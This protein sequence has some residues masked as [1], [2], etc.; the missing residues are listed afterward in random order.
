MRKLFAILLSGAMILSLAGCKKNEPSNPPGENGTPTVSV[1]TETPTQAVSEPKPTKAPETN[2]ERPTPTPMIVIPENTSTNGIKLTGTVNRPADGIGTP[3]KDFIIPETGAVSGWN[4]SEPAPFFNPYGAKD[5]YSYTDTDGLSKT[6]RYDSLTVSYYATD[7]I[8]TVTEEFYGQKAVLEISD[9]QCSIPWLLYT[10]KQAGATVYPTDYN[11]GA[12][13]LK[14]N[15][16]TGWWG[17]IRSGYDTYRVELLRIHLIEPGKEQKIDEKDPYFDD[18]GIQYIYFTETPGKLYSFEATIEKEWKGENNGYSV[19]AVKRSSIGVMETSLNKN[20][21]MSDLSKIT[22]CLGMHFVFDNVPIVSGMLGICIQRKCDNKEAMPIAYSIKETGTVSTVIYGDEP[23]VVRFIGISEGSGMKLLPSFGMSVYHSDMYVDDMLRQSF[24]DENGNYCFTVP[25][26]YYDAQFGIEILE[27]QSSYINLIPVSAG[28]ITEVTIPE[29]YRASFAAIASGYGEIS[30]E[31]GNME[32]I[33]AA[34]K[35]GKGVLTVTVHDPLERD[36]FPDPS[37]FKISENGTEGKITKVDRQAADTNIV[38]C[39]DSSGS[40]RND[41]KATL[42]AAKAFVNSLSDKTSITIVQF[43]QNIKVHAGTTKE[44]AIA[45]LDKIKADGGTSVYDAVAK[46]I[47]L[48]DGKS[49]PNIVVFSDGADSREPGVAGTGSSISKEDI[50]EKIAASQMTVLTIGFGAGHDPKALIQMSEASKN[51][52]YFMA[53]DQS[54]LSSA[55]ASVAS[56]FGNSFVLTYD[57]PTIVVDTDSDIPVV[58]IVMDISGSMDMPPEDDPEQDIDYR[59]EKMRVIFHN[60]VKDLPEQT[61]LQYS[62]FHTYIMGPNLNEIKQ[63]TTKEKSSVLY[64]IAN[65][66][67]YGGTPILGALDIANKGLLPITSSKKVMVF[68]TDAAI[69]PE[70]DGSGG[71]TLQYEKLLGEIKKNGIRALFVGLGGENYAKEHEAV[72]AR[73]AELA[74]GDYIITSDYNKIDEKLK[75]LQ[76]KINEPLDQNTEAVNLLLELNCKTEDGTNMN[77]SAAAQTEELTL[78][79]SKGAPKI[80]GA[81]TVSDAGAYIRYD[82]DNSQQLYGTDVA[83][84]DTNI[85]FTMDYKDTFAVNRFAKL[86]V[87]KVYIMDRFKG[88]KH[89]FVALDVSMTF[90]KEDENAPET[91]YQIPSIFQHFYVSCNNGRMMP[92]SKAT[93]LAQNPIVIPG[94]PCLQVNERKDENGKKLPVGETKSG[95][96]VFEIDESLSTT[97][98]QLS[99]HCYDTAFGHLEIPLI[100]AIPQELLVMSELPKE[101]PEKI[102]DAFQLRLTAVADLDELAGQ[103][104][105]RSYTDNEYDKAMQQSFRVLEMKFR[106]KVQALL[107]LVPRNRFYYMLPTE[108]GDLL[109]RMNTV[110]NNLPLGFTG[111]TMFAPASETV[112]RVP[113]LLPTNMLKNKAELYADLSN[114]SVDLSIQNGTPWNGNT[115]PVATYEHEFFT[116]TV[117][118]LARDRNDSRNI[119]LDFTV[120]DK[121]DGEG[122][123]GFDTILY[124]KRDTSK[125]DFSTDTTTGGNGGTVITAVRS[126]GLGNFGDYSDLFEPLGLCNAD[127][128]ATR[129][130]VFGASYADQDWG[131]FDGQKRRG[132][133]VFYLPDDYEEAELELVSDLMPGLSV[134]PGKSSFSNPELLCK[135]LEAEQDNSFRDALDEAVE[136]R[137]ADYQATH[138]GTDPVKVGLNDDEI[139]GNHLKNPYL[140]IYGTQVLASVRTMDDYNNVM[141]GLTLL[142]SNSYICNAPESVITQGKGSDIELTCLA[143]QMLSMLGYTT[144][145]RAFVLNQTGKENLANVLNTNEN[146]PYQL[147]VLQYTDEN[148]KSH[149]Y[150]PA[151]RHE[152][153]DLYGLGSLGTETVYKPETQKG[154]ILITVDAKPNERYATAMQS[155]L[156]G[157]IGAILGGGAD[158]FDPTK[159]ETVTLLDAKFDASVVGKDMMDI[160]FLALGVSADG[161]HSQVTAAAETAHGLISSPNQWIDL[162]NYDEI[163]KITIRISLDGI[164]GEITRELYLDSGENLTDIFQ[165][166]ACGVPELTKTSAAAYEKAIAEAVKNASDA[167]KT[168]YAVSK[169][170]NHAALARTVLLYSDTS[171]ELCETLGLLKTND[172]GLTIAATLRQREKETLGSVDLLHISSKLERTLLGVEKEVDLEQAASAYHMMLGFALSLGEGNTLPDGKGQNYLNVWATLPEDTGFLAIDAYNAEIASEVLKEKG[173]PEVLTEHLALGNRNFIIP[174]KPGTINGESHYAWLEIDPQSGLVISVFDTGEHSG[175]TAYALG[176]SPKQH[177]QFTVGAFVGVSC[178]AFAVSAYALEFDDYDTIMENA[179]TLIGYTYNKIRGFQDDLG[180]ISGYIDNPLGK[181]KDVMEKGWKDWHPNPLDIEEIY[182]QITGEG[183]YQRPDF[184]EGFKRVAEWYF[185]CKL[186]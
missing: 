62:T 161:V 96:L 119:I 137:I 59:M 1:G 80:P 34:E 186:K 58:S 112:V 170:Y 104:P 81:V 15:D 92:A 69:E 145:L 68:F 130:L 38:L 95:I 117:N 114:G 87:N 65:Q 123:A 158:D 52:A 163:K 20:L 157:D 21:C 148:G 77:Y 171:A 129:E 178:S 91:G 48:L 182:Q 146:I 116:F 39:I 29:E 24:R 56:K 86:Q 35:D 41:M 140:T 135:T 105:D 142:P 164:D 124:L 71:I 108:S 172:N 136:K 110:V 113:Y 165:T 88:L 43:E 49:N 177:L 66:K 121:K 131:A 26:G 8:T 174:S 32:I 4:Q 84:E 180:T 73:A 33:S 79:T 75:E 162:M 141:N 181:A 7:L 115:K 37:D 67:A 42:E 70:D 111:D 151:L 173:Y 176:L 138:P 185:N 46:A 126:K 183:A 61:L 22:P 139:I 156:M 76:A 166:I 128:E 132:I 169:W 16:S 57:R 98:N 143:E 122:T 82:R 167:Q 118:E 144:R 107:S 155:E 5:L 30:A 45:A 6:D 160:S 9:E 10:A 100:G 179:A 184:S 134:T 28:R 103:K 83:G 109:I 74:G 153:S 85:V 3:G 159:Y 13:F 31:A 51:G 97:W 36:V 102:S 64:A 149:A 147:Y 63:I 40:M 94:N 44:E 12:F 23:G 60:F 175:M 11:C 133:L 18:E 127:L 78:K 25:A 55:F 154:T 27:D 72:F 19:E 54:Q 14:E 101:E 168:N 152:V 106:S 120:N 50:I 2:N 150:V 47:D 89:M 90:Q 17:M 125:I 99:L 53:A 93:Y